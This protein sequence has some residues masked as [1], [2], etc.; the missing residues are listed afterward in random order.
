MSGRG[1]SGRWRARRG[2]WLRAWLLPALWAGLIFAGSAIPGD[3]LPPLPG[4][5]FDKLIH[6]AVYGVLGALALRAL[7]RTTRL[8]PVTA[9]FTAAALAGLY[10]ASDEFH[11][12]FTPGRS[13]DLVDLLADVLGAVGGAVLFGAV[14][15]RRDPARQARPDGPPPTAAMDEN[16]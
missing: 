3:G 5:Q 11:Q 4:L 1:E 12:L 16:R 13:A 6:A 8:P 9:I 7:F 2:A 14:K 10:G 15:A